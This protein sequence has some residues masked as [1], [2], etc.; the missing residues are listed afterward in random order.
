MDNL[1][2]Q[3]KSVNRKIFAELEDKWAAAIRQGKEVSLDIQVFYEGDSG[4]PVAFRIDYAYDGILIDS[5]IYEN[6]EEA[7]NNE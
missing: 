5:R 7:V 4:R 3:A 1:V 6:S 2:S